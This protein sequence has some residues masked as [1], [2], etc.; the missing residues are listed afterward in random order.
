MIV[1]LCLSYSFLEQLIIFLFGIHNMRTQ[2]SN[3]LI[4][5]TVP[6]YN[7]MQLHLRNDIT[8]F[9]AFNEIS[10]PYADV[11]LS[12]D[13]YNLLY[14]PWVQEYIFLVWDH[15]WEISLLL[16]IGWIG[17][18]G[19]INEIMLLKHARWGYLIVSRIYLFE[20]LIWPP[21][22]NQHLVLI[23]WESCKRNLLN[24]IEPDVQLHRALATLFKP[25]DSISND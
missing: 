14:V 4:I 25:I 7:L 5:V 22:Y 23:V 16:G 19:G 2:N 11:Q 17:R 10:Y 20:N 15:N 6:R 18:I 1:L 12:L 24:V 21:Q 9:D 8:R 3:D 13:Q